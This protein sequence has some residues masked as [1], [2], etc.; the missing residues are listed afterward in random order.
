MTSPALEATPR[1]RDEYATAL[2]NRRASLSLALGAA[3][4]TGHGKSKLA[5]YCRS[6][7]E[8]IDA[9]LRVVST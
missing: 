7:I 3:E 4:R 6:E 2:R 1:S 9:R 8:D 5:K